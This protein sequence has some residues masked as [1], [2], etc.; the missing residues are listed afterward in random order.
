MMKEL[1]AAFDRAEA[2]VQKADLEAL[3][4]FYAKGYNYYGLKRSDV[5]RV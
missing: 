5:R 3:M 2:A 4:D 1:V